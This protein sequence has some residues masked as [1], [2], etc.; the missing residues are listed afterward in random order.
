[1]VLSFYDFSLAGVFYK[2]GFVSCSCF[3]PLCAEP[4]APLR[5]ASCSTG[6]PDSPPLCHQTTLPAHQP[7]L[8]VLYSLK[9]SVLKYTSSNLISSLW[10]LHFGS[11]EKLQRNMVCRNVHCRY[12]FWW[13][14]LAKHDLLSTLFLLITYR[15][16]HYCK[17]SAQSVWSQ[18]VKH[19]WRQWKQ[20]F[21][22][23]FYDA[24]VTL[25]QHLSAIIT[26]RVMFV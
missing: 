10:S 6:S 3:F 5:S 11:R 13:F 7:N 1:M 21:Q 18:T 23:E 8:L 17:S 19:R 9:N 25:S 4:P 15:I 2:L 24:Q 22:F 16:L 20:H 14:G 12:L 26:F